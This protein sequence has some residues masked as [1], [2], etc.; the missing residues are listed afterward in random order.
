MTKIKFVYFD[1]GNVFHTYE[2]IFK[3]PADHFGIHPDDI[4]DIFDKY[5][6]EISIG[7]MTAND[8]WQKCCVELNL[9]NATN[10][11]FARSWANDYTVIPSMYKLTERI[12][13]KY[14][15]GILSN[16]YIGTFEE[17]L[18]QNKIPN[19]NYSSVIVSAEVG[20][21]KPQLEIFQI[22]EEKSGHH[23]SEILFI[24]D[25][26]KNLDAAAKIGWQTFL[27][28]HSHSDK[29]SQDLAKFL[30]LAS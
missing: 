10:F 28:D 22:A 1:V 23:G 21:K 4:G 18:K 9:P 8:L 2:N 6:S 14:K 3:T 13:D 7:K 30:G 12:A 5:E 19:I 29:S 15:T 24:D 20:Y 25:Q 11:D 16:H 17:G 26:Q 27:Y